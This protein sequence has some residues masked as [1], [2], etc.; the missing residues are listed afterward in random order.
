MHNTKAKVFE[1]ATVAVEEES[2]PKRA[3]IWALGVLLV[4]FALEA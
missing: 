3:V 1:E 2:G 4:T